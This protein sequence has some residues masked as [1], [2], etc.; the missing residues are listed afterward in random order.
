MR[1]HWACVDFV[2][3]DSDERSVPSQTENRVAQLDSIVVLL[4]VVLMKVD[5]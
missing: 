3:W 1:S 4:L 5:I 2:K